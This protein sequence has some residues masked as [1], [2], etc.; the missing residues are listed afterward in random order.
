MFQDFIIVIEIIVIELIVGDFSNNYIILIFNYKRLSWNMKLNYK[1]QGIGQPIVF[2]H[3]VFGS[4]DNLNMLAKDLVSDYQTIQVDLRN[5]G[6]SPWSDQINYPAMAQDVADL[7]HELQLKDI[8]LIGHSMGGKV[9]MQLS[10]V[11]PQLIQK[12]VVID[13]APV[14]YSSSPN[15]IILRTLMYCLNNQITDRK[16]IMAV[17]QEAGLSEATCLFLLKSYKKQHW[18]FNLQVIN[19]QYANICDW[20]T[21]PSS[22]PC[23]KSILFIRGGNSVYLADKYQNTIY[24]QFPNAKI[25]TIEGAGHNVHA[26][27][28]QQVLQ[29]LHDW[30]N[31]SSCSV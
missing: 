21:I 30:L 22:S 11:I 18:L 26:E 6:Q 14:K 9:A 20:Q 29:L 7:C 23:L 3:G 27:K 1:L 25:V 2:L 16:Q 17:M 8:I 15:A 24:A 5:H 31:C 10:Q 28:T 4:L 12:I 13:I 19:D